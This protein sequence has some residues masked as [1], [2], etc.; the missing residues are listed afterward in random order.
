[1]EAFDPLTL[2]TDYFSTLRKYGAVLP[3]SVSVPGGRPVA[4]SLPGRRSICCEA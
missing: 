3:R 1:M 2:L 4:Q